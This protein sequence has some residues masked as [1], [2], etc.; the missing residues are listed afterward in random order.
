MLAQ[1]PVLYNISTETLY[2]MLTHVKNNDDKSSFALKVVAKLL[3]HGNCR[4]Q[5]DKQ[6]N[7][8]PQLLLIIL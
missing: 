4:L 5:C 7:P 3:K 1:A 8:Q 6:C 2:N